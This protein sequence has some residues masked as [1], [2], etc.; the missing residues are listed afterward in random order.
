VEERFCVFFSASP[1]QMTRI[2]RAARLENIALL[3]S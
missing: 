2:F 1:G 3:P